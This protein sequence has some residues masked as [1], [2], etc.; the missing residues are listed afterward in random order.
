MSRHRMP[1]GYFDRENPHERQ[2]RAREDR[3][4]K[5]IPEAEVFAKSGQQ[6]P[7]L[8]PVLARVCGRERRRAT[9]ARRRCGDDIARAEY[10]DAHGSDRL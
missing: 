6:G 2:L 9:C 5:L 4:S 1:H 8:L 10:Q 7:S 3:S